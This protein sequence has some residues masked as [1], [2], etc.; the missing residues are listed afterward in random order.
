M[1]PKASP[2]VIFLTVLEILFL[3]CFLSGF[4]VAFLTVWKDGS[5]TSLVW[6][7]PVLC[8]VGFF[9][10]FVCS[11]LLSALKKNGSHNSNGYQARSTSQY[12]NYTFDPTKSRDTPQGPAA[13]STICPYCNTPND[14]D[15]SYCKHCGAKL[16]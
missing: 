8:M 1:K 5:E 6:L 10:L 11:I 14:P 15:A 4:L 3:G 2:L 7:T 16:K 13:S 9:G 12:S